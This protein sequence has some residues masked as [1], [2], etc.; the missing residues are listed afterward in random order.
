MTK[1]ILFPTPP[2]KGVGKVLESLCRKALYD[3]SLLE[4]VNHLGIALSGGKD[5][6]TLLYLLHAIS[7]RGFQPFKITAFHVS[8]AFSCGPSMTKDY[9]TSVCEQLG[10]PL[11]LRESRQTIEKLSCYPCSRER[12]SLLFNAAR[13]AGVETIAFGHH[14]DDS[15]Q[16]LLLN[17]LHKGEFAANL[18][19]VPMQKMGVTIIRPLIYASEK[20][21]E[22]FAKYY[23]FMRI[24]CQCPVGAISKRR[25]V[26]DILDQLEQVF[27]NTRENLAI[28][29]LESG[30][31]KALNP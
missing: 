16:T 21:I 9:L 27:P 2:F 26:K 17:L 13:E 22:A 28:A 5:S 31:K 15:I 30:S 14:K 19:K 1:S 25:A 6:L 3:F 10:V 7:G 20:Q 12:R 11:I 18:P 4:N 23:S 24:M 8:G 29:S